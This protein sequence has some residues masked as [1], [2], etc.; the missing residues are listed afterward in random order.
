MS[1]F[2][3]TASFILKEHRHRRI[4]GDV[5]LIG[6]QT[7]NLSVSAAKTLL[8][9]EG[10]E[11]R[12]EFSAEAD[13]STIGSADQNY[14]TDTAFFSLFSSARVSALDVSAY[15]GAEIIHDLN[16]PLPDK[17]TEIA[18]FI[19]NGSCLDNLF[20]P[21]T[22]I[23]SLSKMLRPR[24]RIIHL[25]HGTAIQDAFL[26][27]S[28]EWFFDYY[29][30]NN[31]DDCQNF[32]CVFDGSMQNPWEVYSWTAFY[33]DNGTLKRSG[34]SLG[35][36]DFVNIVVAEKGDNSTNSKTPIQ[37]HYREFHGTR[38]TNGYVSKY[39]QFIAT[40]R[41][42]R[43]ETAEPRPLMPPPPAPP[44]P[45]P[46]PRLGGI[47]GAVLETANRFGLSIA[48]GGPL[49]YRFEKFDSN[50]RR[51]IVSASCSGKN[52]EPQIVVRPEL[53]RLGFLPR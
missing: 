32:V 30:I 45:P 16:E 7:V 48:K 24:G 29:A 37:S 31:Y 4:Q 25:E 5:L 26:C 21:A 35:I 19:F 33:D 22:A 14:I 47:K 51:R 44:P 6:R 3:Q 12:A 49:L 2:P 20:D 28:P 15:E 13:N 40:P 8:E 11:L 39:R 17:Y 50:S 9:R 43:F 1:I 41:V 46:P 10:V 23:T 42:Y 53:V 27:Y 34:C 38:G 52:P 18:D 36:G